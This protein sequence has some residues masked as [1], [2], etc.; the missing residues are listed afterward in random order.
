MSV[1]Q[2]TE[3]E[4]KTLLGPSVDFITHKTFW[5]QIFLVAIARAR[6]QQVA[7]QGKLPGNISFEAFLRGN[8]QLVYEN[9]PCLY[10]TPE[11]WHSHEAFEVMIAPDRRKMVG[12]LSP[13]KN[14]LN[15]LVSI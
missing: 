2:R 3:Y 11:V 5:V 7:D 6:H 9:L 15:N 4:P 10:Y 14:E 8:L 1:L 13:E 12:T